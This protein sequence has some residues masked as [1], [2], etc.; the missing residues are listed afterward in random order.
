LTHLE[1]DRYSV[2]R[3]EDPERFWQIEDDI[4]TLLTKGLAG[5]KFWNLFTQCVQCNY[6]MP[7]HHFPYYHKC[8]A[9][10]IRGYEVT[11]FTRSYRSTVLSDRAEANE[12]DFHANAMLVEPAVDDLEDDDD[13]DLPTLTSLLAATRGPR[14]SAQVARRHSSR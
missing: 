10:V 1:S 14:S 5:A 2:L 3:R 12:S 9:I 7:A 11:A 6:V 8:A 13:D 4:E